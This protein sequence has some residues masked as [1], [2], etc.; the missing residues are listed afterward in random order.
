MRLNSHA[1]EKQ[2]K[3]LYGGEGKPSELQ[4][5]WSKL[6]KSLYNGNAKLVDFQHFY[7][8]W[9]FVKDQS[10]MGWIEPVEPVLIHEV[11]E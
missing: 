2:D 10:I 6:L 11:R 3:I 1:I 8:E 4:A 5:V 9:S 7:I